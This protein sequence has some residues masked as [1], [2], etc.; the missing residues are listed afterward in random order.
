MLSGSRR[1][2]PSGGGAR[3]DWARERGPSRSR[4][5]GPGWFHFAPRRHWVTSCLELCGPCRLRRHR[6][7]AAALRTVPHLHLHNLCRSPPP[8]PRRPSPAL[9]PPMS[10]SDS[11]TEKRKV[12]TPRFAIPGGAR[13]GPMEDRR[14]RRRAASSVSGVAR[15]G[16][17]AGLSRLARGCRRRMPRVAPRSLPGRALLG[18]GRRHRSCEH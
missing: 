10:D 5:A 18:K 3:G 14:R 12:N 8:P 4:V 2:G 6:I 11:R 13:R 9:V 15:A 17:G 1:A 7:S 16:G